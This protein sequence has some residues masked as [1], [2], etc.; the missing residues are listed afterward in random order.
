MKQVMFFGVLIAAMS[1]Y[2][3]YKVIACVAPV[4]SAGIL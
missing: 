4:I 3:I 1:L 2:F